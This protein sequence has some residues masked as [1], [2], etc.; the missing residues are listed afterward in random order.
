V[1]QRN[2][3]QPKLPEVTFVTGIPRIIHQIFF[4][5]QAAQPQGVR[6][7]IA[8]IRAANPGWDYRFYDAP[9]AERFIAESYGAAI[10]AAYLSIDPVYYAARSDLLRYLLCYAQGGVYL[11][12][13]SVA[14][15]PL[16]DVL[17]DDDSFLI[18]QWKELRD[19]P[20]GQSNH[21]ETQ[22]IAGCEYVNWFL[23]SAP[24]HPFLHAVIE[25]VLSNIAAY[26]PLSDGVGREGVLRLTGPIAYTLA[27]HPIRSAHPHRYVKFEADIGFEYSIYGN[28]FNHR[29]Q[30]G[31]HYSLATQP[32]IIGSP[33]LRSATQVWYGRIAPFGQRVRNR[34][35]RLMR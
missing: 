29:V 16:D 14:T 32:I 22:H 17:R 4:P 30:F 27:I 33:A 34:L 24:G 18:S 8:A 5:G 12:T 10:L 35:A 23:V 19:L 9:A 7:S 31:P 13:K 26:N 25:A 21:P 15:L 20:V 1:S 28:P 6:D 2:R 3:L 11:D